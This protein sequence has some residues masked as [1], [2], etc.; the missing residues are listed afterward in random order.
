MSQQALSRLQAERQSTGGLRRS[1][2]SL[3]LRL[4][5]GVAL[6]AAAE[7][8]FAR[9]FHEDRFQP[10]VDAAWA[11]GVICWLAA[12]WRS[13]P[14]VVPRLR[15]P[16]WL[17]ALYMAAL[18]PFSTNWRWTMAGDNLSWPFMGMQIAAH[19]P[20][21]SVLSANGAD[22]FGYLQMVLHDAFM[23]LVAPTLFWHRVGKI[24]VGVLAMAAVYS[25][26][27]R[28]VTPLFGM[29]V[30][31]CAVSTSVWIVY[32]YASVPF[33]D[34]IASGYALLAIGLWVRRNSKSR[35][36]WLVL[37]LLSGFMLFLTP[38]GWFMALCVWGWLTP[39]VVFRR[40]PPSNFAL[41]V[42]TGLVTG[43]PMLIQ[44]SQGT[45]GQL[46]SLVEHP[47]W[48]VEKVLRFLYEAGTIPFM[49]DVQNS[50]A[51]GPQLP[52]GFRW[53]FVAGILIAPVFGN[54]RF[55]GARFIFCIYLV[56]VAILAFAQ[57]PYAGVSVKRA[58]VLIP[59]A[60]YFAFLPF[61]RYLR[62]PIVA[63]L[64]AAWGFFGVR[65]LVVH[66][67]PGHTGYNFFDGVVEAHQRFDTAPVCVVITDD[68]G[69]F[70]GS[71]SE[72][73]RLYHLWPHVTAVRHPA[74]Q[75]CEKF[76][77]YCPQVVSVDLAGLGYTEIPMQ[78][79]VELRCG[80]K[81]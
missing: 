57:G 31:A 54:R 3:R 47:G 34:G 27:A 41:A 8:Y 12:F 60:T 7:L 15:Q 6:F 20:G 81:N 1:A 50:G 5:I 76:L 42:T 65:D 55:P 11:V 80:R 61:H 44:W 53:L 63:A 28:L 10:S 24:T 36:A 58:L 32:T 25:V 14:D 66:V 49:S 35:K 45:G 72:L 38:N 18:L 48:T 30:A 73:D 77:C 51:F 19:G 23:F 59:M 69:K 78:N 70:I 37:G 16:Y 33:M 52:V 26:F 56:H 64:I 21:R 4:W 2:S 39:Q 62:A 29:L 74:D 46:F 71:G 43:I 67:T 40:W 68:R 75:S 17:Y 9:F 79:T 22:N 13:D